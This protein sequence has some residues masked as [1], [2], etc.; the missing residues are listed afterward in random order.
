[1][2][3]FMNITKKTGDVRERYGGITGDKAKAELME[4]A[5]RCNF[6]ERHDG[7]CH[8]NNALAYYHAILLTRFER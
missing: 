8:V 1:V 2:Y 4:H 7:E 6:L 5:H 3:R